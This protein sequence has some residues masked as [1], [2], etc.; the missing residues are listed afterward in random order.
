MRKFAIV[1]LLALAVP[2]AAQEMVKA[3]SEDG[4]EK[5]ISYDVS[6]FTDIRDKKLE[7]V[8]RKMPGMQVME[9]EGFIY[10]TYNGMDVAK[11]YVN[12][13]DILEGNNSPVYNMKPEDVERL[14]ITENHTTLKIMKGMEYSHSA[15]INV[16]LK[17][18]DDAQWMGSIKGGLGSGSDDLLLNA[19]VNALNLG[20]KV[21]TMVLFKADNT[22][23]NFSGPLAGFDYEYE[24]DEPTTTKYDFTI[25]QYLNVAPALA[26]L[27]SKRTRLNRSGIANIAS[28][29]KL[30]DDYQLNVQ[31]TYHN[32]RLRASNYDETTYYIS[33]GGQVLDIMGE[34]AKSKQQDIQTDFT[35][36]AN[37]D[38]KYLRNQLSFSTRWID[39]DKANKGGDEVLDQ[40]VHTN[41]LKVRNDFLYKMHLGRNILSLNS[42]AG[43][44]LRPQNLDVS[45]DIYPFSQQIKANSLYFTLGATYDIKLNRGLNLSLD[46]GVAGNLRELEVRQSDIPVLPSADM[47]TSF[48]VWNAHA[49]A[50]LT[51]VGER[52]QAE[53]RM[54]VKFGDYTMKDK[55]L[56]TEM[57]KSKV[58]PEPKLKVKYEASK[59]LSLALNAK[60]N[61]D[62]INRKA[63]FPGMVI[64]EFD[65]ANKGYDEMRNE[66]GGEVEM[67]AQYKHPEASFF[68][69][70]SVEH[71]WEK[72][73]FVQGMAFTEYFIINSQHFMPHKSHETEIH[74][75]ISKGIEFMKGK[76]GFE[77]EYETGKAKMVRNDVLIPY[78]ASSVTFSPYINGRLTPWLNMVYRLDYSLNHL[79]MS[80][81]ETN[82]N[83][84]G[85]TQSMELIF[86]PWKKLN[87]SVLGEHYYTE[88][89]DDV[90]KHLVLMDFKAEYLL[91]DQWQLILSATNI[92]NQK[93]YN[94]TLIDP[95]KFTKSYTSYRI[96]ERDVLLSL[97][98]KF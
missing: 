79:K 45:R 54:P 18:S 69:N 40:R 84:K 39:V 29:F 97:Y 59:N 49:E 89:T 35:L 96:R 22:G 13:M 88:F 92:L 53:L 74:G 83:S 64:T 61:A 1:V 5:T 51:Y 75:D 10:L 15:A 72:D 50:K 3:L 7:D 66:T 30:N 52:L 55:L 76:I 28:T 14:E 70:G 2:A 44:N 78:S 63:T 25:K 4:L 36:L 93:T 32:D 6:K 20:Q 82:P 95:E 85:Y 81:D 27:A 48:R 68:V 33:G 24:Y 57:N 91:S 37:T 16:V 98:Y 65:K 11:I 9:W 42:Q 73:P 71:R 67:S 87:F 26:P 56:G 58:Y 31:L 12:G 17:N 86:S 47:N 8:L 94:Y 19:D 60:L 77:V 23:L 21:Q 46:A 62:E 34:S 41:P 38:T 80:D 90:S 43:F